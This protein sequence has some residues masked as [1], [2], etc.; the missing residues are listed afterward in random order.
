MHLKDDVELRSYAVA[1]WQRMEG[2]TP[3]G[4]FNKWAKELQKFYNTVS[5]FATQPTS[6]HLT[7]HGELK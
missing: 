7:Q 5:V 3:L 1:E 2:G 4:A 6:T